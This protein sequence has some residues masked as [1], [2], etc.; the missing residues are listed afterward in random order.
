MNTRLGNK[1][2]DDAGTACDIIMHSELRYRPAAKHVIT[3][4]WVEPPQNV[5]S[6]I[7]PQEYKLTRDLVASD[8]IG[9]KKIPV[10]KIIP[11]K[12]QMPSVLIPQHQYTSD[13]I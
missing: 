2:G 9:I 1:I 4:P 8:V 11:F 12:K 7:A 3:V 13:D 10:P 6:A 5:M